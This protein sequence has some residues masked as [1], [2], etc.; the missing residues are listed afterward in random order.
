[1]VTSNANDQVNWY[2]HDAPTGIA[3]TRAPGT[4]GP[5]AGL[6][7]PVEAIVGPDGNVYV[8]GFVS[9]NIVRYN[10]TTGAFIDQFVDAT[11]L[12]PPRTNL[13][14]MAFGPDGNLYVISPL[15]SE[16]LRFNRTTG[17]FIDAFVTAGLGGLTD[18]TGLSFGP[19]GHLYVS[20]YT[21]SAVYRY[22]G[23][24]GASIDTFVT[25]NVI[26]PEDMT[27]GPDGNGDGE[28]DLYVADDNAENVLRFQGP[29]GVSPGTYIDDFVA[30]G[31]VREAQGVAFGPD[32]H[33]YVSSWRDD[34][35]LR[36]NRT[37]GAYIDDYVTPGLGGLNTAGYFSFIPGHQVMVLRRRRRRWSWC[38][39]P[40]WAWTVRWSFSGRRA[41][42]STTWASTC[43]GPCRRM[44]PTSGSRRR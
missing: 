23:N 18:P 35:V 15:S 41:P 11:A 27:F 33:L 39:S 32:G 9:A 44:V 26:N 40:R 43:T 7:E 30:A 19:D 6:T 5:D 13:Y 34:E 37:T 16:V 2:A 17:A 36:F 1:M 3:V 4:S 20:D 38:R 29:L 22:D 31:S 21:N 14:G 10:P 8:S 25:T 28:L 24:T 42:R 12:A